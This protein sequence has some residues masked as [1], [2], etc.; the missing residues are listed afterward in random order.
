MQTFNEKNIL[1]IEKLKDYTKMGFNR[2]TFS[3]VY[4]ASIDEVASFYFNYFIK[5]EYLLEVVGMW[6]KRV[7]DLNLSLQGGN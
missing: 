3:N 6:S 1:S 4:N 7:Q 5:P 2:F